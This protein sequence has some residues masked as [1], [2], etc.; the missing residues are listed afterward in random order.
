MHFFVT[1]DDNLLPKKTQKTGDRGI[2]SI[3]FDNKKV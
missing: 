3:K 2:F 1:N